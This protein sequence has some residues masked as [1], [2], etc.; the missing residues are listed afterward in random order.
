MKQD[1]NTFGSMTARQAK[2]KTITRQ[3][4]DNYKTAA[5]QLQNSCKTGARLL[6]DSCNH[7]SV[8]N[9][10]NTKMYKIVQDIDLFSKKQSY[11]VMIT[12]I[13]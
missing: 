12:V 7:A 13:D 10:E 4:K 5:R 8:I 11:D 6:Q 2:Y 3:L 9:Q 1:Q